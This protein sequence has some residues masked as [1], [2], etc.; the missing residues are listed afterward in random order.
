MSAVNITTKS[1]NWSFTLNNY[2][3]EEFQTLL[4]ASSAC[5]VVIGREVGS[6]NGVPHLQGYMRFPNCVRM[7]TLSKI[8]ARCH[9]EPST[10]GAEFNFMYCTKGKGTFDQETKQWTNHGLDAEWSE[11]GKRPN[12][13]QHIAGIMYNLETLYDL[14]LEAVP[15]DGHKSLAI[16][17][18]E[19]CGQDLIHLNDVAHFDDDFF[20]DDEDTPMSMP[21][22][23]GDD[24]VAKKIRF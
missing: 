2:S 20:S 7:L 4:N 16:E 19:E 15:I 9:W 5:Y 17:L 3:E 22:P 14:V 13:N 6:E 23:G 11:K 8:N 1:R 24:P 18:L 21:P 12:F 10:M